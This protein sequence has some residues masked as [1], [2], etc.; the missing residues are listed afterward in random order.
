M[1]PRKDSYAVHR[2]RVS[3]ISDNVVWP[4][5]H[6][7][8]MFIARLAVDAPVRLLCVSV[9]GVLEQQH[10]LERE[11][12]LHPSHYRL[13]LTLVTLQAY[14]SYPTHFSHSET[15]SITPRSMECRTLYKLVR[16]PQ[17]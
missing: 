2:R 1:R 8:V 5:R 6:V 14:R 17:V 7:P 12:L 3:S 16:M 9:I 4:D 11:G 15:R 10:L 13:P